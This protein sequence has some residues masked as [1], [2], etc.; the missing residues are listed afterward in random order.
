MVEDVQRKVRELKMGKIYI[1]VFVFMLTLGTP[2]S[3]GF[4]NT[5][6]VAAAAFGRG[7]YPLIS[8][9]NWYLIC[10][11]TFYTSQNSYASFA[12]SFVETGN[13]SRSTS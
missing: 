8:P 9:G 12:G 4:D 11:V 1:F 13:R 5:Y 10:I 7:F 2:A 3:Q 6:T